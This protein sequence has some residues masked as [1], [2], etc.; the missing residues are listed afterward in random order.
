MAFEE[1]IFSGHVPLIFGPRTNSYSI[2]AKNHLEYPQEYVHSYNY[3]F[4]IL[5]TLK[6]NPYHSYIV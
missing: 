5:W 4:G 6:R 1:F 2:F 3:S